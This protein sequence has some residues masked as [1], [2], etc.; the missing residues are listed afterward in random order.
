M[1]SIGAL[2][3]ALFPSVP[4]HET[5]D[6]SKFAGAKQLIRKDVLVRGDKDAREVVERSPL[7]RLTAFVAKCADYQVCVE[8][9]LLFPNPISMVLPFSVVRKN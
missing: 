8:Q 9:I 5:L 3:Q 6:I 4:P 7:S 1:K 2:Y